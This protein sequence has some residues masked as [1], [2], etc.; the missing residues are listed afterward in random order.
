MIWVV[1]TSFGNA[2]KRRLHIFDLW[3]FDTDQRNIKVKWQISN[4]H[5]TLRIF[6]ALD[7]PGVVIP[8][9]RYSI[10]WWWW[11]NQATRRIPFRPISCVCASTWQQSIVEILV[12][13]HFHAHVVDKKGFCV[14]FLLENEKCR[15]VLEQFGFYWGYLFELPFIFSTFIVSWKEKCRL[16]NREGDWTIQPTPEWFV[17]LE[18]L[19]WKMTNWPESLRPTGTVFFLYLH[20]HNSPYFD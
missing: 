16:A 7:F 8:A 18:F 20:L 5:S 3:I 17:F 1:V 14:F 19:K 4:F 6:Q 15:L 9:V 13:A 11:A 12:L 10:K 2:K